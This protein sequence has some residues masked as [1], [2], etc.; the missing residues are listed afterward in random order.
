MKINTKIRYGLR[1]MIEICCPDNKTGILQKKIAE[2]Q[3]LSEKYL[4]PIIS[5]LKAKGLIINVAGKK[6]GYVLNKPSSK[7][8]VL[9][10][11]K[12]FENGPLLVQCL[13]KTTVCIRSKKCAAKEFW[14]GLNDVIIDYMK[15]TTLEML[16]KRNC[17]MY[18]SSEKNAGSSHKK[19]SPEKKK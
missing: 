8:A 14:T 5:A 16:C 13:G 3:Q 1:T 19:N 6:S 17:E 9:D 2:N 10:I 11:F 4:D 12:A 7:I 15:S 18:A